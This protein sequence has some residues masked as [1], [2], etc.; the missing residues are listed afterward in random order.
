MIGVD[1]NLDIGRTGV[2]S[3]P[4]FYWAQRILWPMW[5]H[6][7]RDTRAPSEII[8]T[9][10]SAVVI[11]FLFAKKSALTLSG[12]SLILPSPRR[13]KWALGQVAVGVLAVLFASWRIGDADES[14][15]TCWAENV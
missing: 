8:Q 12:A 1:D 11:T 5:H 6:E 9:V 10:L 7:F 13:R 3:P 15:S 4:G 2:A 14:Y